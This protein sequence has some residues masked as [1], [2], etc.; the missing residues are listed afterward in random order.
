MYGFATAT[1]V[2]NVAAVCDRDP[3]PTTALYVG[4]FDPSGLYMSEVDLPDRLAKY[5]GDNV[6]VKRIVWRRT[7]YNRHHGQ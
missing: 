3:R 4:D 1:V 6:R 5:G 2:N 7:T